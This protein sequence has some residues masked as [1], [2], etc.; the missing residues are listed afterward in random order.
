MGRIHACTHVAPSPISSR[1]PRRWRWLCLAACSDSEPEAAAPERTVAAPLPDVTTVANASGTK[2]PPIP[3]PP[4]VPARGYILLD[5]TSNQTL[6]ATNEN[7]RLE[8]ASL[9]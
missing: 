3:A 5:Y 2:P 9:T 7:E 1:L 4:Q 6:A 8:P